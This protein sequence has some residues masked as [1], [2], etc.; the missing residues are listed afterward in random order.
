MAFL[1]KSGDSDR[2][3]QTETLLLDALRMLADIQTRL[4][5]LQERIDTVER[6]LAERLPPDILTERKFAQEVQG[7]DD[8]IGQIISKVEE[9]SKAKSVR[10]ILESRVVEQKPSPVEAKRMEVITGL[11]QQHGKI[12]SDDLA[13]LMG[14]SRTRCNEYFKRMEEIGIVEPVLV[15][16][17]KFYRLS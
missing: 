9:L 17:E 16:K 5:A 10:D 14:L 1:F 11:L 8:I 12:S 15:G 2:K 7:S 6:T 13:N 3:N 4:A